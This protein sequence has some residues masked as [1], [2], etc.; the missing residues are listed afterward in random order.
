MNKKLQVDSDEVNLLMKNAHGQSVDLAGF[1]KYI[2]EKCKTPDTLYKHFKAYGIGKNLEK[3]TDEDITLTFS[4]DMPRYV[5]SNE[6]KVPGAS[7][8]F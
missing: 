5:I 3:F 8:K 7:S 4:N 2:K 6:P 1:E